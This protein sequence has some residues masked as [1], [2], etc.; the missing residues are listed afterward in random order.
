M[1]KRQADIL[2]HVVNDYVDTAAPVGSASIAGRL[3]LSSATIRNAMHSL[4]EGGYLARPHPSAGRVPTDLGYRF[5]VDDLLNRYQESMRRSVATRDALDPLKLSL[6]ALLRDITRRL[7][8]WSECLSFITIVEEDHSRIRKLEMA[9][10]SRRRVLIALSL[11]R[12]P[13]ESKLVE[14]PVDANDLP[15]RRICEELNR[16]LNG[17]KVRDVTSDSIESVFNEI[18]GREEAVGSAL[19]V[20]FMDILHRLGRKV[21]VEGSL[22]LLDHPEFQE[23]RSLKPVLEAVESARGNDSLFMPPKGREAPLVTIGSEHE[24]EELYICSSI[25]NSFSAGG[26]AIGAVGILGPKRMKY[27]EMVSL[28]DYAAGALNRSMRMLT[29]FE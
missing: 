22:K 10:V 14:L 3:G 4:E 6:D 8:E 26:V 1:E 20:F 27:S 11:D 9:V 28:V 17:R 29:N 16:R 13:L 25:K 19:K 18:R 2:G 24:I 21:Y 5:V 12:G 15:L 23:A 7:A